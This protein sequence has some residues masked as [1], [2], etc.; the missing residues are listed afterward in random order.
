MDEMVTEAKAALRTVVWRDENYQPRAGTTGCSAT[1]PPWP[2]DC[3]QI[4]RFDVLED[5]AVLH[6]WF[7]AIPAEPAR[8]DQVP[9]FRMRSQPM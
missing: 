5:G 9:T 2:P 6:L 1:P 4:T 7:A 3:W 8:R